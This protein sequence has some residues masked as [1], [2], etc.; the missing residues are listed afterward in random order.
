MSRPFTTLCFY[1]L[2]RI[3]QPG[4]NLS[5]FLHLISLFISFSRHRHCI[6][7]FP[8]FLGEPIFSSL[9]L[10]IFLVFSPLILSSGSWC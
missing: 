1:S 3:W 4:A 6:L 7:P 9:F 8:S 2:H 5:V 10:F